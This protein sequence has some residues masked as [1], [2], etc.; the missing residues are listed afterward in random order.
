MSSGKVE[1]LSHKIKV[2]ESTISYYT[3]II[4][5]LMADANLIDME[6]ECYEHKLAFLK[7]ELRDLQ[8]ELKDTI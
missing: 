2:N 8:A 3:S 6:I 4:S 1:E 7:E 5:L